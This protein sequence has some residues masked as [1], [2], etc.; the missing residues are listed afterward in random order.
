[1][2]DL[3][4]LQAKKAEIEAR[5][6]LDPEERHKL[7]RRIRKQIRQAGGSSKHAGSEP[8]VPR[9]KRER[10]SN[11]AA[12]VIQSMSDDQLT[13]FVNEIRAFLQDGLGMPER[14]ETVS[15]EFGHVFDLKQSFLHGFTNPEQFLIRFRELWNKQPG[16]WYIRKQGNVPLL[17]LGPVAG[18]QDQK[19]DIPLEQ[20]A[21]WEGVDRPEDENW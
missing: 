20:S 1:M 6:D 17:F 10:R 2:S 16:W 9:A 7:L 14:A 4:E 5:T 21:A 15:S 19:T 13:S 8:G 12:P 18:E 11:F 3:V